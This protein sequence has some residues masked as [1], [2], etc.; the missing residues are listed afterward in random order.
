MDQRCQVDELGDL[1]DRCAAIPQTC[2]N[3]LPRVPDELEPSGVDLR[4]PAEIDARPPSTAGARRQAGG[5]AA[6]RLRWRAATGR[7]PTAR[8][9]FAESIIALGHKLGLCVLAE[10]IETEHVWQRLRSLHCDEGQGYYLARR[11]ESADLRPWISARHVADS[12]R[13]AVAGQVAHGVA[14]HVR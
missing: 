10:G 4:R 1:G 9:T 2:G 7:S 6:A 5:N 8:S 13:P 14:R 11:M 3:F 12:G